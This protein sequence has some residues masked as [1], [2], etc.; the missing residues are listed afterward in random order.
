MV[1]FF[2]YEFKIKVV[3]TFTTVDLTNEPANK[4]HCTES[5][6]QQIKYSYAPHNDVS[7]DEAPHIRRWSHKIII[8]YYN[9]I[10]L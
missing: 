4:L 6:L 1:H 8:S 3:T 7:V 2:G 10:V 9:I 5:I